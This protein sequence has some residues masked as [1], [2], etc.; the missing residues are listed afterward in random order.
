MENNKGKN[1]AIISYLTFIGFIIAWVMNNTTKS[2]FATFHLRQSFGIV[3]MIV[4]ANLIKNIGV[5]GIGLVG[6][7]L[8]I[9]SFVYLLLGL[10]SAIQN[11]EKPLPVLGS[12]FQ[13]WFTF[14]R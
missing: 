9:V 2:K 8:V 13:E 12:Y 7:V 4:F 11:E 5:F 3:I 10:I 6:S 1:I 14:I